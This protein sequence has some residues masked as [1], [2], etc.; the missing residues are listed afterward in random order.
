MIFLGPLSSRQQN[1]ASCEK[2]EQEWVDAQHKLYLS[3]KRGHNV[4][5]SDGFEQGVLA[6]FQALDCVRTRYD[7]RDLSP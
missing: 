2:L 5:K 1:I 4:E 3:A 6:A 7:K